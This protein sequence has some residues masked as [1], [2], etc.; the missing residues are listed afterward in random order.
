[1]VHFSTLKTTINVRKW[2]HIGKNKKNKSIGSNNFHRYWWK[3]H[4]YLKHQRPPNLMVIGILYY[5]T[6]QMGIYEDCANVLNERLVESKNQYTKYCF[7]FLSK[8]HKC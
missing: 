4:N 5:S 6:S 7:V 3:M 2:I 1:M 8:P